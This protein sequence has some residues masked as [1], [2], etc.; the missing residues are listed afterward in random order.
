MK[1]ETGLIDRHGEEIKADDWIRYEVRGET[2]SVRQGRVFYN[3]EEACW[4][5]ENPDESSG[6]ARLFQTACIE[7]VEIASQRQSV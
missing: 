3:T 1:Q 7:V 4:C 6:Y 2:I 5:V